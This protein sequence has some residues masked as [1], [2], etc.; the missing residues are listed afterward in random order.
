MPVYS[1]KVK[2]K[3]NPDGTYSGRQGT[4]YD[5]NFTYL[6]GGEKKTYA[7][8]GFT[9]K[10]EALEHEATMRLEFNNQGVTRES[11]QKSKM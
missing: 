4:V 7:K 3:K 6:S 2:N 10:A 8:G 11:L 1:R 5:V 9:D